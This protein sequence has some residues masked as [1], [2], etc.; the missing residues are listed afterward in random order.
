MAADSSRAH[1]RTAGADRG[2]I[3][4]RSAD[5]NKNA[6]AQP[7]VEKRAG[8]AGSWS[9]E[10]RKNRAAFDLQDVHN[11]AVTAHHHERRRNRRVLDRGRSHFGGANHLWQDRSV[12]GR[13]AR[14]G[15]QA[16]SSADVVTAGRIETMLAC[17]RNHVLLALRTIDAETLGDRESL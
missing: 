5:F 11:A 8:D 7:L 4:A 1:L 2:T 15:S 14:A 12:Q 3:R 9:G 13:G 16:V 10:Q 17:K 6:F